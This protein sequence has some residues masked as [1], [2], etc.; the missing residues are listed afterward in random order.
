M[1]DFERSPQADAF[2]SLFMSYR[3][4]GLPPPGAKVL[5]AGPS[6]A[7][8][9]PF[10]FFD[11]SDLARAS[12]LAN[13]FDRI[14]GK[15]PDDDHL[16]NVMT[17]FHEIAGDDVALAQ[18]A[19]RLF[20]ARRPGGDVLPMPTLR[21]QLAAHIS[22]SPSFFAKVMSLAPKGPPS[23]E[24]AMRYF[25][26]DID[27]SDHH[28][29]WHLLYSNYEPQNPALQGQLFLYMHEQCLARYDTERQTAGLP[30]V[31][32]LVKWDDPQRVNPYDDANLPMDALAP[33]IH[34]GIVNETY[35]DFNEVGKSPRQLAGRAVAQTLQGLGTLLA[36]VNGGSYAS[37]NA[38]GADAEANSTSKIYAGPH[39]MGHMALA[40]GLVPG[41]TVMANPNVA[42]TTPI[43]YQWHRA[44]DDYGFAWQELQPPF[45][46]SGVTPPI[47]MRRSL[48]GP[49]TTVSPDV[50][51][52][53][54]SQ[55]TDIEKPGFDL[56]AFG[57]ANFGAAAFDA[58]ANSRLNANVL[59]TTMVT[60]VLM[61]EDRLQL[62]D[63]W[64][65][66]IRLRNTSAEVSGVTVRIWLAH[67]D[68]MASRRHWIEMDKF[69]VSVP[70]NR[71]MVTARPGWHST[72]VRAKSVDDVMQ[73]ASQ[74]DD[75]QDDGGA[76]QARFWCECGLP[77][78]LL[79]PRGTTSGAAF[80]FMVML[81][82]AAEDGLE[83]AAGDFECGSV[84]FCGKND[85]AWPDKKTM[86]FPF[87]RKF[88][89]AKSDPV[90]AVLDRLPNVAWRDVTITT[91]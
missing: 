23:P 88:A 87:D 31:E 38:L 68:L 53:L 61:G 65:Y 76:N 46:W 48:S 2:K 73:L 21:Q 15:S 71:T 51:L 55:I 82:D 12:D 17:R 86:G 1:A 11:Q 10:A 4:Q 84:S 90:F 43:F 52:T 45:T 59:R 54:R 20:I 25:R 64:V 70:G 41:Q 32:P 5:M 60:D 16:R 39:N 67:Q 14:A 7:P 8:A 35:I 13:D 74:D 81:T 91:V 72:V 26:H 34:A 47:A 3:P 79:L 58:P 19:L 27:L 33:W 36:G 80:R 29:H 6:Q 24:D 42:M 62:L 40:A 63:H 57:E 28:L 89:S 83:N 77:Y 22:A 78:R 18:W 30:L 9:K 69:V 50:I 44:V 37:Y 85:W 49:N 75:Y 66:F 56:T